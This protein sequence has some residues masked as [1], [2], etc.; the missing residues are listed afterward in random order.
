MHTVRW[1]LG[2]V[3]LVSLGALLGPA[4][5]ARSGEPPAV[6]AVLRGRVVD[7]GGR[8]LSGAMLTLEQPA[9][10]PGPAAV[11]VFSDADGR[12]GFPE[13]VS[14][15][16]PVARLLGYR[17]AE[18]QP[19]ADASGLTILMRPDANQA[20]VAPASAWLGRTGDAAARA[21]VVM[22]CVGCHQL[23]APEVR[24]WA[25]SQ[26]D[27]PGADAA[28]T[29]EGWRA[30]VHYM[31]Y[32][33]AWEF[34][35][36]G[37]AAPD[38]ARVYSGGQPGP[39]ATALSRALTGSFRELTGYR[40]GAPLLAGE[41]AVIREYTVPEPNAIR[42]AV[43]LQDPSVLWAADVSSNRMIRIDARSG[44]QSVHEV[45]VS[46]VMGPHTLVAGSDGQLWVTSFFPG[47]VARLDPAS[48]K[49]RTWTLRGPSGNLIGVHD[50]SFD[51]NHELMTDRRGR[52]WY[53]DI[54]DNAVGWLDPRS[55]RVGLHGVPPVPGRS[56]NEQLYGLAMNS[57]RTHVWYSQLGIGCFGSFNILTGQFETLVQLED[58]NAG[59]RRM[60][61]SDEDVLYVALFG[62]GQ[63]AEYDTRA[64]R[65]IGVYDLPDRASAPYS[66][67]WDPKRKVVWIATS[68]ANL[69][70]RFDPRD[71]SFAV[72]PL[73]RE[74]AF[75][76]M[77]VVDRTSG[78]LISSYANIV[79]DVQGPRS[80]VTIDLGDLPAPPARASVPTPGGAA[81]QP[82]A[83][84]VA[85]AASDVPALL[86]RH[87]CVA[88]HAQTDTLIGPPYVAIAARHAGDGAASVEVLARK[89]VH[90]GGGTWGQVPMPPSQSLPLAEART[91]AGWVLAQRP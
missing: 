65:M 76:R 77:V 20:G 88:C 59:P 58:A 37:G 31:N 54:I 40:Y 49:W 19:P 66:T 21:Q 72:L 4:L 3:V 24:A 46:G 17:M 48:G 9:G 41:R 63:L 85:A 14:A 79:E 28:S 32:L 57:A 67:T 7:S 68:N 91:I 25:R 38:A 73:P 60:S 5:T 43:T 75:L 10:T 42:E 70:Y 30:M 12:F 15:G 34:G 61:M 13:A 16:R 36:A 6:A 83:A 23:P 1:L 78:A 74:A 69:L 44:A 18:D 64:R 53:S 39:M 35:R 80:V 90:G 2:G 52:I 56:G 29:E 8:A 50:L 47:T 86:Q 84:A 26:Q 11:T 45:P 22:N 27:V 87:R 82:G 33:S 55:G 51:A 89:I 62:S 81:L 71:K